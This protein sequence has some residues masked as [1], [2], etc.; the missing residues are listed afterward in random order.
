M[1]KIDELQ[2]FMIN[3]VQS[4]QFE[5]TEKGT[6]VNLLAAKTAS[7]TKKAQSSQDLQMAIQAIL[8]KSAAKMDKEIVKGAQVSENI[9]LKMQ[10]DQ[11][12]N[13]VQKLNIELQ[14]E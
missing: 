4:S 5:D 8:S 13:E 12:P 2:K 9:E 1:Q 3:L 11:I 14:K 10:M 6:S 7:T